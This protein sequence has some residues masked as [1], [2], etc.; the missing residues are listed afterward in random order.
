M[1]NDVTSRDS[2]VL[3]I[4]PLPTTPANK[5]DDDGIDGPS[6]GLIIPIILICVFLIGVGLC[7]WWNK[8]RDKRV[9][10]VHRDNH[11]FQRSY[12]GSRSARNNLDAIRDSTRSTLPLR[13]SLND[14]IDQ[15]HNNLANISKI[16]KVNVIPVNRPGKYSFH[17][18]INHWRAYPPQKNPLAR[19]G[20]KPLSP[21]D[22]IDS[23]TSMKLSELSRNYDIAN[24][25][26]FS[27][28]HLTWI[29][30]SN[31]QS[32]HGSSRVYSDP[33]H[34]ASTQFRRSYD[35][36]LPNNVKPY[37]QNQNSPFFPNNN[38]PT[39]ECETES[40]DSQTLDMIRGAHQTGS[41]YTSYPSS[42]NSHT[43]HSVSNTR[44]SNSTQERNMTSYC[45]SYPESSYKRSLR[46]GEGSSD[47]FQSGQTSITEPPSANLSSLPSSIAH[48][49]R[50]NVLNDDPNNNNIIVPNAYLTYPFTKGTDNTLGSS[51][52]SSG[53]QVSDNTSMLPNIGSNNTSV[54]PGSNHLR[55]QPTSNE[56]SGHVSPE[57]LSKLVDEM[58][59]IRPVDESSSARPNSTFDPTPQIVSVS[60]N[61]MTA[62]MQESWGQ[63]EEQNSMQSMTSSNQVIH[64]HT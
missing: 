51:L 2:K 36:Y 15:K 1:A 42:P 48:F 35:E 34:A 63:H 49:S 23:P 62:G 59:S 27:P 13:N 37:D 60:S 45:S 50:Q 18:D 38:T 6:W 33:R 10:H 26:S 28:Y 39:T 32:S 17:W 25:A 44:L 58:S 9:L 55:S 61:S 31:G 19:S 53:T 20:T 7:L 54:Y 47:H 16:S 30:S 22:E 57:D 24:Q 40:E 11:S 21:I 52:E 29:N 43:L 41:Q 3:G 5:D 4:Q 46:S 14:K 12:R 56:Q 8:W 64:Y